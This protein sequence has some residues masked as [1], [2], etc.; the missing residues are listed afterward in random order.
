MH[1]KE[2]NNN[3]IAAE[4]DLSWTETNHFSCLR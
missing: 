1:S 2:N 3:A 4:L